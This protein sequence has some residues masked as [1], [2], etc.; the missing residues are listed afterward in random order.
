MLSPE[1]AAA[2]ASATSRPV[3]ARTQQTSLLLEVETS[4]AEPRV[5]AAIFRDEESFRRNENPVRVLTL[6]RDGR[7]FVVNLPAGRYA[8]VAWQDT[9]GDGKLTRTRFGGASEPHG[10]SRD[11]RARVGPPRFEDAAFDLMPGGVSQRIVLRGGR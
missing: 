3:G 2:V 9:D 1:A 8:I 4:R 11:A 7:A 5:S 10:Y 6:N